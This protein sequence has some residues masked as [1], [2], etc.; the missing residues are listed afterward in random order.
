MKPIVYLLCVCRS[1]QNAYIPR[2]LQ[3][4]RVGI[5]TPHPLSHKRVWDQKGGGAH[6]PADEGMHGGVPI[7]DDWRKGLALCLYTDRKENQIFLIHKEIQNGA[8]AKSYMTITASSYMGKY[9]RIS[10][11]ISKTFL[12]YMTLQLLHSEFPYYEEKVD[13]PFYQCILCAGAPGFQ[14]EE[15][16]YSAQPA[17]IQHPT[18]GPV[19]FRRGRQRYRSSSGRRQEHFGGTEHRLVSCG[20]KFPKKGA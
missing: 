14:G 4:P 2:V 5:G 6:S 17:T 8:A 9:L 3:C 1:L 12:I 7:S 19:A 10:S 13:F 16:P 15:Q 18:R 11:H 20:L